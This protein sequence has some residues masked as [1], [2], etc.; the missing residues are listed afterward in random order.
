MARLQPHTTQQTCD[1]Q[2]P[3][4]L[5]QILHDLLITRTY[6]YTR[7]SSDADEISTAKKTI[8]TDKIL[9]ART[10]ASNFAHSAED[11]QSAPLNY[12]KNIKHCDAS[13][14][15]FWDNM[16]CTCNT[17]NVQQQS[18]ARKFCYQNKQQQQ[19]HTHYRWTDIWCRFWIYKD[20]LHPATFLCPTRQLKILWS[21]FQ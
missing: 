1:T 20:F 17:N 18:G 3:T 5:Q 14:L 9:S 8:F 21:M 6:I 16:Y 19:Q 10:M 15:V 11:I 4:Q 13:C 2:W 12:R 7:L